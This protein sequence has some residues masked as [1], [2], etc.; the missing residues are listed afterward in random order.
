MPIILNHQHLTLLRQYLLTS[1]SHPPPVLPGFPVEELLRELARVRNP[2]KRILFA[3][4]IGKGKDANTFRE[5]VVRGNQLGLGGKGR[6]LNASKK[7]RQTWWPVVD[8]HHWVGTELKRLC[9]EVDS[10][11]WQRELNRIRETIAELENEVNQVEHMCQG[12][13]QTWEEALGDWVRE[14]YKQAQVLR[15]KVKGKEEEAQIAESVYTITEK[16]RQM[17]F[18]LDDDSEHAGDTDNEPDEDEW[19]DAVIIAEN[20]DHEENQEEEKEKQEEEK[21]EQVKQRTTQHTQTEVASI[22]RM[23]SL[24]RQGKSDQLNRQLVDNLSP[25]LL[26]TSISSTTAPSTP[27]SNKTSKK[28]TST[29][30]DRIRKKLGIRRRGRRKT[31]T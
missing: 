24:I 28:K 1:P 9:G 4:Q 30:R 2:E 14:R 18:E 31:N 19:E 16:L 5:H 21:E 13:G 22:A 20:R 12:N 26:P 27:S 25:V 23:V 11:I 3:A 8:Q 6:T 10:E 29:A 7:L 17:G 15:D